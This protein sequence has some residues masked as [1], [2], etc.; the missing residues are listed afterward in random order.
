MAELD[1]GLRTCEG[2]AIESP[3]L[4]PQTYRLPG[5]GRDPCFL[6]SALLKQLQCRT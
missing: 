1:P 6:R 4:N 3:N 5:E 2:I